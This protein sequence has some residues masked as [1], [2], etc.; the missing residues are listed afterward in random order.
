MIA[1]FASFNVICDSLIGLPGLSSG[2]WYSW[3][4]IVIPITG[5]VLGPY[6]G[7][8]STFVGVLIGHSIY[9]RD[10]FEFL[11]T[12]GAPIGAMMTG[13]LYTGKWRIVLVYYTILLGV[14][15]LT[16]ISWQLPIIGIWNI[17]LAYTILLV[18]P[19][20]II[21]KNS[22][23]TNPKRRGYVIALSS[24]VGLEADILFRIFVLIPLQTYRFFY[25]IGLDTLI[26]LWIEAAAITPIKVGISVLFS[27]TIRLPLIKILEKLDLQFYRLD[28][29]AENKS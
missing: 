3:I 6:A 17:L 24:I 7:F 28:L 9:F 26:P 25:N 22:W 8:F 21:W 16:P 20:L 2:V 13:F 18:I 12:F 10:A 23:N 5:I 19:V 29:S 1:L 11:F 14:Y 27:I 15:F 4:F